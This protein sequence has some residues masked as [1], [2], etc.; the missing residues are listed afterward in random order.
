MHRH[1]DH[2]SERAQFTSG[3]A[4]IA[5]SLTCFSRTHLGKPSL[6]PNAK[7]T[8][9]IRLRNGY[10]PPPLAERKILEPAVNRAQSIRDYSLREIIISLP[11]RSQR[12][13]RYVAC[14]RLRS[15]RT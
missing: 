8:L 13:S 6:A 11:D 14:A 3:N 12:C 2:T 7:K 1:Q 15:V 9:R 5:N 10:V 4:P